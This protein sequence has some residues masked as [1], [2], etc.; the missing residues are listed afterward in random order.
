[1]KFQFGFAAAFPVR[2][3]GEPSECG[4][5]CISMLMSHFGNDISLSALRRDISL[6][7]RGLTLS[8]MRDILSGVGIQSRGVRLEIEELSTLLLP[9]VLHMDENH[10]VVLV[11]VRGATCIIADPALGLRKVNRSYLSAH[12][13]GIALD[14]SPPEKGWGRGINK[15]GRRESLLH[16]V[17]R[18]G[19]PR[20]FISVLII[21]SLLSIILELMVLVGPLVIQFV[22]DRA[23]NDAEAELLASICIGYLAIWLFQTCVSFFRGWIS[24]VLST[25]LS[26]G[27]GQNVFRRLMLQPDR[28]FHGRS[29]GDISSRFSGVEN[30]GG[31][32]SMSAIE[33]ALDGMF[34]LG[35]LIVIFF[36]SSTAAVIA[37]IGVLVYG[38]IKLISFD[39]IRDS[40][41][42][43]ISL[44]AKKE[45][46]FIESIRCHSTIRLANAQGRQVAKYVDGLVD[47][48]TA[49]ARLGF[50]QSLYHS[51][52]LVVTGAT[53]VIL[54][55][56]GGRLIAGGQ[57][58]AGMLVACLAYLDQ[59][60]GRCS[61]LIDYF[62]SLKI[63][64]VY[65]DR[66]REIVDSP[67][68]SD[69]YRRTLG[70]SEGAEIVLRDVY[71]RYGLNDKPV[72]ECVNLE[73]KA[74]SSTLIFGA[75]GSGKSTLAKIVGG[76]IDQDAGA[77]LYGGVAYSQIGKM[78]VRD[79]V[80]MVSASDEV[81]SGSITQNVSL[82]DSDPNH[83]EVLSCCKIAGVH[84]DILQIPMQYETSIGVGAEVLSS[85]QLQRIHI[86]RALYRKPKILI[87]DEATSM[88]D[89]D[90][91]NA[92]LD[93][94]LA[95]GIGLLI[96]SHRP[97]LMKRAGLVYKMDRGRLVKP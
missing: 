30:L 34:A 41:L 69:L 15:T 68:E 47:F 14:V 50:V 62:F 77:V 42:N 81:L 78:R 72:L 10:F 48:S 53:R 3:Q 9:S 27:W 5:A 80:A 88:L 26:I 31:V 6:S 4:L 24:L 38:L 39:K 63:V 22:L 37:I 40:N 79:Y 58:S 96:I 35:T 25:S 1:M 73:L 94:I 76:I 86:A 75:S 71:F 45:S 11:A 95:K 89:V 90:T 44:G 12:F 13:T 83:E 93:G 66:L 54:I 64:N 20:G 7:A 57:F 19:R 87:L 74:G 18:L 84:N 59:F 32:V 21:L 49:S 65:S 82:F 16:F 91:E 46:I 33:A 51:M 2:L 92:V 61:K 8:G 70:V 43:L 52:G 85:G 97:E 55:F 56:V 60:S 17:N 67:V 23:T 36:Y 29:I 28:Y